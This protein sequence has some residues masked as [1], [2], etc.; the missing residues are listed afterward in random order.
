[1]LLLPLE[2]QFTQGRGEAYGVEVF[3]NKR[4]GD[5]TGW[6]GYTLSWTRRFFDELNNGN[7]FW[8]RYDRRHDVSATFSYRLS[9]SLEFGAAW[10][11]GTGFAY[12]MPVGQ[13]VLQPSDD[14]YN[15]SRERYLYTERNGY[16]LPPYHRLDLNFAFKT[17]VFGL[18]SQ[19]VLSIYNAYNRQNPFAQFVDKEYQSDGTFKP[20]LKQ[21]TLF[22]ILPV[23][24]WNFTF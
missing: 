23:L 13:Y 15:S 18:P 3:L 20:V 11:F 6:V 12:T 22:P 2:S 24:A 9:S 5:F 7:P 1:S 17:E 21:Y 8:A 16:R 4:L 14:R 19:L 10:T